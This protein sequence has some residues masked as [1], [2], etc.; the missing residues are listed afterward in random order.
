VIVGRYRKIDPRIW[1]DEKFR[2][3][4][5]RGKLAF[6]FVLTHP[7]MT[8]VGAMRGT[9]NGLAAELGWKP[10]AMREAIGETVRAGMIELNTE[11]AYIGVPRFLRYNEPEGP[12][13]VTKAWVNAIDLI[14]ECHEKRVL[15]ERCRAYLR[16]RSPGFNSKI[17]GPIW[18]L[19]GDAKLDGIR[20]AIAEGKSEPCSIQEQE[21]E[22]EQEVER[23][24][25]L[26]SPNGDPATAAKLVELWN[27]VVTKLP[28]VERLTDQRRKMAARRL[29]EHP[30]LAWWER[31]F[32]AADSDPFYS[33]ENDR[34]WRAD[35]D[36]L[37]KNDTNAVRLLERTTSE[38]KRRGAWAREIS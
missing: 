34:R 16:A 33:G 10:T 3:L 14:P 31:A 25:T 23:E 8:C 17:N 15:L 22:Q 18:R 2:A 13:S 1:N 4:S 21:Q 9:V 12:N 36:W 28:K 35:F 11:A 38:P 5:D 30:E 27:Q 29:R 19:L 26:L 32:R 37:L 6:I 7:A 20:D 24:P